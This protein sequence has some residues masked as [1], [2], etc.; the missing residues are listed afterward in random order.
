M[1]YQLPWYRDS[2]R[3][4]DDP[5]MW[6]GY[7]AQDYT[8][9]Y[10]LDADDNVEAQQRVVDAVVSVNPELAERVTFDSERGCFFAY[11]DTEADMRALVAVIADLVA[12][13]A[14]HAVPG[15]ITD[16]PVYVELNSWHW[17]PQSI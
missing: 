2:D 9:A 13:V 1:T 10:A 14:P 3:F 5:E 16:S 15:K 8:L 6:R 7:T 4:E 17:G 12:A 11:T